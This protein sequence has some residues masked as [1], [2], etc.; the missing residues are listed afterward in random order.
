[1]WVAPEL[2]SAGGEVARSTGQVNKMRDNHQTLTGVGDK[3][4]TSSGWFGDTE[5]R[6]T[7]VVSQVPDAET[8]RPRRWRG[9]LVGM[10]TSGLA[11]ALLYAGMTAIALGGLGGMFP[12]WK[13][14]RLSP[15]SIERRVYW[16]GC[17]AGSVLLFVSQLP[18]WRS[19]SLLVLPP[20]SFWCSSRSGSRHTSRSATRFMRSCMKTAPTRHRRSTPTRRGSQCASSSQADTARSP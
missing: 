1:M 3:A 9:E 18:D 7:E 20:C 15:T 11:K 8:R 16:T 2:L 5:R 13:S 17:I 4:Q 6:N 12:L 10:E 14:R 19:V